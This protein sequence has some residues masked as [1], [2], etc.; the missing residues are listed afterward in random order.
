MPNDN[1]NKNII[2]KA[3]DTMGDMVEKAKDTMG[4]VTEKT[5]DVIDNTTKFQKQSKLKSGYIERDEFKYSNLHKGFFCYNCIYWVDLGGGKCMIVDNKGPDSFGKVSDVIAPHGCCSLYEP[6]Y[7]EI[8][9]VKE[10]IVD[11]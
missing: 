2:E 9:K 8:N 4:D 3:A 7:D 6:D 11:K 10:V 5:S 1:D